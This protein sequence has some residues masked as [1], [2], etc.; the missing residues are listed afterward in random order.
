VTIA[1]S[2]SA[3]QGYTDSVAIAIDAGDRKVIGPFP[4]SRFGST[5]SVAWS[6][7]TDVTVAVLKLA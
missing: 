7:V 6:A 4:P 2:A 1:A 5:V 3:Q